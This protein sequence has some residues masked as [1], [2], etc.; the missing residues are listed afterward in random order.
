M[1]DAPLFSTTDVDFAACLLT[2][3]YPFEG[4]R[5]W[6]RGSG[7][8]MIRFL[9][10]EAIAGKAE[11]IQPLRH[12]FGMNQLTLKAF[13]LLR[14]LRELKYLMHQTLNDEGGG[15]GR[16]DSSYG[17]DG[18]DGTEREGATATDR[19]SGRRSSRTIR[20]GTEQA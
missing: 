8:K 19:S 7:K 11:P 5:I 14:N 16:E 13:K 17:T 20:T 15:D 12:S 18:T 2:L 9:F 1:D 6:H 4:V 10:V 3:G